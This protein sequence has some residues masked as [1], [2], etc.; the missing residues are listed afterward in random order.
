MMPTH[1]GE[2]DFFKNQT[3]N[4]NANIFLKHPHG[5]SQK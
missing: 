3:A 5:L 2:S 1:I 4:L